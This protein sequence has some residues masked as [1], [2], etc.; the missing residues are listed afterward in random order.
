MNNR[1]LL[2]LKELRYKKLEWAKKELVKADKTYNEMSE[3]GILKE[4]ALAFCDSAKQAHDYAIEKY[5][6]VCAEIEWN[7]FLERGVK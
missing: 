1:D 6:E 4:L 5:N 7:E 3:D 2:A